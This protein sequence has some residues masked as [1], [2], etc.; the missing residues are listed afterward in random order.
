M[1]E[2]ARTPGWRALGRRVLCLALTALGTAGG[3]AEKPGA[4]AEPAASR[5]LIEEMIAALADERFAV[6]EQAKVDLLKIGRPAM[7]QL[8]DAAK[9]DSPEQRFRA[10]EIVD[11]LRYRLLSAEFEALG[12]LDDDQIEVEHGMWLIAKILDPDL[13]K[14][15]VSAKLDQMAEAV[16]KAVGAKKPAALPPAEIMATLTGVLRIEFGLTGDEVTYQHPD[17]SSVHRVIERK[18]GLPIL[19]SE[20]GVAVARRLEVPVVGLAIPG[21]YM[22]KY[23]GSRAPEGEKQADIIVNPFEGWKATNPAELSRRI[24]GFDPRVH[25]MPSSTRATLVRMLNNMHA[26]SLV[27]RQ[28]RQAE[29]IRSFRLLLIEDEAAGD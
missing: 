14:E 15:S 25:L 23:E 6:R 13:T 26:H 17:N 22:I 27:Q 10:A 19:L 5:E 9:S 24:R 1:T 28:H 18:R 29:A 21:R 4:T 11:A 20:I 2:H 8:M 12:K 16:R 3:L 7:R